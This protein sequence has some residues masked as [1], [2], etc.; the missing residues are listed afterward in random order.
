LAALSAVD[1]TSPME[2]RLALAAVLVPDAE[3]WSRFDDLLDAYWYDAGKSRTE[4]ANAHVRTQASRPTL[5][6]SH[7]EGSHGGADSTEAATTK[8]VTP[9]GWTEGSSRRAR[10]TWRGVICAS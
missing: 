5:W 10:R 3:G 1:V 2:S 6:R 8:T 9:K 4:E 7:F